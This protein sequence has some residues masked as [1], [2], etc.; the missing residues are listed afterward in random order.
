MERFVWIVDASYLES[1]KPTALDYYKLK[2]LLEK[3]CEG[4]FGDS[5]YFNSVSEPPSE[6]LNGFHAWLKLAEP[7]GPKMRVKLYKFKDMNLICPDCQHQFARQVQKGVDVGIATMI[8]KL[9]A[10]NRYSRL[11][12]STGDG[13]FEDAIAYA[14]EESGKEIW[15][16]GFR[17]TV[18]PDLQSYA[19]RILWLEDYW[20]DIKR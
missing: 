15:V 1:E 5:F 2:K 12:P 16:T 19:D 3:E 4:S 20:D 7:Q 14:R 8:V 9:A 6:S 17:G 13:D 11:V 18:S 10:Q